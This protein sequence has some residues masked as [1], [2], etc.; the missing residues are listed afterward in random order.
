MLLNE[1]F[2]QKYSWEW[3][4]TGRQYTAFFTTDKEITYAVDITPVAHTDLI[5]NEMIRK[6]DPVWKPDFAIE[7]YSGKAAT[8]D[9]TG[10]TGSGNEFL[11]FSTV[12]DI[13]KSF[14]KKEKP[15]AILFSAKE[16]SRVKL[17]DTFVK[18][19][20]KNKTIKT[21]EA[22]GEKYYFVILNEVE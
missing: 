6:Y 8:K 13:L 17:Y 21:G 19:N 16:P 1:L 22:D 5:D 2:D 7:Q 3:E 9:T 20:F 11:V 15:N 12:I 10:I 18:R 4:T 14:I